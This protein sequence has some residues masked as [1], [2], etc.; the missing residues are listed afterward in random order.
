ML[1]LL[2]FNLM[3]TGRLG[4]SLYAHVT[5]VVAGAAIAALNIGWW[6]RSQSFAEWG[7]LLATG[8]YA[9]RTVFLGLTLGTGDIGFWLSLGATIII[10]GSYLL[11]TADKEPA[12]TQR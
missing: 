9:S 6:A 12:W 5:A 11:E 10:G 2:W 8:V 4:D 1:A 7:L 3:D